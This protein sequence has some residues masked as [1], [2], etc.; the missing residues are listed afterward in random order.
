MTKRKSCTLYAVRCTQEGNEQL[1]IINDALLI[2]AK[3][4]WQ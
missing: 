1:A 2:I 4:N 3:D